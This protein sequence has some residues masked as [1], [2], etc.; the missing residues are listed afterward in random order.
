MD[1]FCFALP[2]VFFI[3]PVTN[4]MLLYSTLLCKKIARAPGGHNRFMPT[5]PGGGNRIYL[6]KSMLKRAFR[7]KN[8]KCSKVPGTLTFLHNQDLVS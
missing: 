6:Y 8:D 3:T 5:K 4:C 2:P 7:Q 1:L